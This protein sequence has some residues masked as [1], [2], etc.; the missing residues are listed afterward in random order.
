MRTRTQIP[1]VTAGSFFKGVS[2]GSH[3]KGEPFSVIK[4]HEDGHLEGGD[5]QDV[6]PGDLSTRSIAF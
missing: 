1:H 2:I 4:E 5:L 3:L 6:L